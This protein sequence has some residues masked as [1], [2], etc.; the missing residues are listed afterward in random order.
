MTLILVLL[1]WAALIAAV[2][3]RYRKVEVV[4]EVL[5][6]FCHVW[7][8]IIHARESDADN[9]DPAFEK[10]VISALISLCALFV[11]VVALFVISIIWAA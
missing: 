7:S 9:N 3:Y 10:G 11:V 2:V 5:G 6:G 1:F 4:A 8:C